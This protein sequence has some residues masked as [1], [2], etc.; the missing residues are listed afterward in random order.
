MNKPVN[1]MKEKRI[2]LFV[3]L[4]IATHLSEKWE[5]GKIHLLGEARGDLLW[6]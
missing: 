4:T 5:S 6:H 1:I 2:L 3:M